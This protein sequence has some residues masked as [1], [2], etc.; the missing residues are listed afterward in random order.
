M[1]RQSNALGLTAHRRIGC[2]DNMQ[3][4]RRVRQRGDKV[5]EKRTPVTAL[6]VGLAEHPHR[7]ASD[8]LVVRHFQ[9]EELLAWLIDILPVQVRCIAHDGAGQVS[10]SPR[11]EPVVPLIEAFDGLHIER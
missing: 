2:L 3:Q 7:N 9:P 1:C 8:A 4:R 10:R 6:S 5:N 11:P